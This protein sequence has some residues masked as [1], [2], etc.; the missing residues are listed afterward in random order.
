[1]NP[2]LKLAVAVIRDDQDRM[3]VVRKSGTKAFM[4][5]GGKIDTGETAPQALSRELEE[6]LGLR[7]ATDELVYM[8]TVDA[9]AA[10]EPD[11]HVEA[12]VFSVPTRNWPVF[13]LTAEIEEA[14]WAARDEQLTLAPLTKEKI[15]PMLWPQ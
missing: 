3:L 1:M 8:N 10:N 13:K 11:T 12:E 5:P 2:V 4:Q 14:K 9:I 7:V 6:E 15:M